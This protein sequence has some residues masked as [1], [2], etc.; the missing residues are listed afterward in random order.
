VK[1][2]PNPAPPFRHYRRLLIQRQRELLRE[3]RVKQEDFTELREPAPHD[4]QPAIEQASSV[5]DELSAIESSELG[6]IQAALERLDS[7]TFGI[8]ER[9]SCAISSSRL[10][11]IPWAERCHRCE[12][13]LTSSKLAEISNPL[14]CAKSHIDSAHFR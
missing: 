10:L 13:R 6:R 7:E 1:P 12:A 14:N 2:L 5:A 9:C 4:D 8:C 11:A 3:L